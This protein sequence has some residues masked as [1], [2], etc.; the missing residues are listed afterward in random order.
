MRKKEPTCFENSSFFMV[1]STYMHTYR[2]R[3]D[4]DRTSFRECLLG[5]LLALGAM[6]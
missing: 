2:K 3:Q 6:L 5:I 1:T 4:K